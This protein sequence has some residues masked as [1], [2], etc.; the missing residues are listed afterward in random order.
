MDVDDA[1]INADDATLLRRFIATRDQRAFAQLVRR[2][3]D[4]VYSAARRQLRDDAAAQ[5]VTQQVF[6]LLGEKAATIRDGE[7]IAGWLLVTTRYVALNAIRGEARRRRHEREAAV[8]QQENRSESSPAWDQVAPMLDDAVGR[9]KREDRDALAL[10]YFQGRSVADVAAALGVSQDAAQKRLSRAL[11]RLRDIFARRGVTTSAEAL[12]SVL[13]A[14]ALVVAPA[15]LGTTVTGAALSTAALTST[16]AKGALA[17]MATAKTKLVA[18]SVAG[19][20]L[21]GVTG[22]IAYQQL[23]TPSGKA[24][25]VK[26]DPAATSQPQPGVTQRFTFDRPLAAPNGAWRTRFNEIYLLAPNQTL[27][28]VRP[29]FIPERLSFYEVAA[30]RTQVEAIPSGPDVMLIAQDG[31][32]LK[33]QSMTFGGT[34]DVRGVL[35]SLVGVAPHETDLPRALLGRDLPGD[36]V[37][38]TS[39]PVAERMAAFTQ[40]LSQELRRTYRAELRQL[41]REVIVVTGTYTYRPTP[42]VERE[43]GRAD[44][45]HFYIGTPQ[46]KPDGFGGSGGYFRAVLAHLEDLTGRGVVVDAKL[47]PRGGPASY[48][49]HSSV[50][51]F[52][53]NDMDAASLDL[54]LA[55]LAKQ[56]SFEF[57]RE[58]RVLP[59]WVITPM[60]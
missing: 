58:K 11:E 31:S 44:T 56:T 34:E 27:K 8:M 4:L 12:S 25:Q 55:N 30:G 45:V 47:P 43:P 60:Q 49:D 3:V 1:D 29:P 35:R 53:R 22:T 42:D 50:K 19:V 41:E 57:R 51:P 7:A 36:F 10:R 6:V 33:S 40:M 37:V 38:R 20:M 16:S 14:N 9:L 15:T 17:I 21:V 28:R 39:A 26:V 59:T 5:D 46:K 2:H 54:L 48:K 32:E 18:A 13:L 23:R 52:H 24:R